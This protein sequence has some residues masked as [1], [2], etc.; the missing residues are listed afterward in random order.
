MLSQFSAIVRLSQG[1]HTQHASSLQTR[2]Y[3]VETSFQNLNPAADQ[4]IYIDHN[5]RPF[6]PP[7]DV[8]F[9]PC[10]NHYDT[11]R[12]ETFPETTHESSYVC[13]LK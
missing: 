12:D 6:S 9:E 8:T 5:I 13:R 2:F 10:H 11:V 7:K 4:D 1:L 3:A